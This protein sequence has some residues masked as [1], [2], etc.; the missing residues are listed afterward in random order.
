V[1]CR[2]G[3]ARKAGAADTGGALTN[4]AAISGGVVRHSIVDANL[5]Q[6]ARILISPRRGR[7]ENWYEFCE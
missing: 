1:S 7:L 3:C 2:I 5:S 4:F 6:D